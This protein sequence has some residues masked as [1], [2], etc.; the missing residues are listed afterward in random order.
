M[1][2]CEGILTTT[3]G[4]TSHAA[5]VARTMALPCI[6]GAAGLTIDPVR[7]ILTTASGQTLVADG[8]TVQLQGA[9]STAEP[10]TLTGTGV[11]GFGVLRNISGGNTVSGLATLAAAV[12]INSDADTL[13]LS[14][15]VSSANFPLTVGGAGNTT[16]SGALSLGSA[17]L[18]KDGSG[19]LTLSAGNTY[20][21]ATSVTNGTLVVAHSA[22]LGS[23]SSAVIGANASLQVQGGVT[24]SAIA[25]T[26]PN[27]RN[28]AGTNA[29]TGTITA[30]NG[31]ALTLQSDA[32]T[33]TV[34]AVAAQSADTTS[35]SLLLTGSA[36]GTISGL[37]TGASGL[38][39]T[40]SG[41]WTLSGANTYSVPTTVS[42][43]TLAAGAANA[44]SAN[45]AVTLANAAGATL[46][47]GGFNQSV[48]SL[49]GAGATGGSVTLGGTGVLTTGAN[50]SFD[51]TISGTGT[52][53]LTKTGNGVMTL[54]PTSAVTGTVAVSVSQ[55]TLLFNNTTATDAT[56]SV[57]VA[58]NAILGGKGVLGGATTI[59]SGGMLQ[60]GDGSAG[61]LTLG[62]LTFGANA[63]D[64]AKFRVFNLDATASTI[65]AGAI[66][67]NGGASTI[68]IYAV[69]GGALANG[70]YDLL[71]Y[72]SL[73]DPTAFAAP[74]SATIT[75]LSGRQGAT[76]NFLAGSGSAGTLQMIVSGDSPKWTGL[77]G[78]T[79]DG[80]WHLPTGTAQN[81]QL[82]AGATGTNYQAGDSVRFDDSAGSGNTTVTIGEGD[83]SPTSVTIDNATLA[84]VFNGAYGL[85]GSTGVVKNG[86]AA[87]TFNNPNNFAGGVTVNAGTLTF[88]GANTIAGGLTV[89]GGTLNL[90]AANT[91]T[92][93]I[94]IDDG[95]LVL[96][97]PGAIDVGNA[98]TFGAGASGDLRL[99]GNPATIVGLS[100]NATVGTPLIENG[101][102]SVSAILTVNLA[103]GTNTY[104]GVLQDG[105]AA[106]LG[107][108]KAGN[109]TLVLTGVNTF[110]G[111]AAV[112]GGV[113]QVGQGGVLSASDTAISA[114]AS[115]IFASNGSAAY[116]GGIT[117]AGSL[118]AQGGGTLT[119][120][121]NAAHTGG[122]TV[123]AGQT[124]A[125]SGSGRLSGAGAISLAG[126]LSSGTDN[127]ISAPIAGAGALS[128]TAGTLIL[129]GANS[130]AG[131][132][133]I[134][135]AATLQ[136]GAG[137]TTGTLGSAA[138]ITDNG[139][140]VI[141]RSADYAFATNV[142]GSGGLTA[143]MTSGAKLTLTGVNGYT[144]VTT[145][146]SGTLFISNTNVWS[147]SSSLVLGGTGTAGTLDLNGTSKTFTSL[148]T[149]GTASAQTITN[150]ATGT[151][152]ITFTGTNS[153]FGGSLAD[154]S[155]TKKIALAITGGGT[156]QL[157]STNAF[158]GGT[159]VAY[160]TAQLG[161]NNAFG[162]GSLTLGGVGTAGTLDLNGFS[163]SIGTFTLGSG[164]TASAQVVGNS[165]SS[166]DGVLTYTGGNL[167][168]ASVIQDTL[169]AGTR[170]TG[171][172]LAGGSTFILT[173]ANTFTGTLI[174]N[175]GNTLQ[176]GSAGTVGSFASPVANA[177]TL[178][179][180]RTDTLSLPATVA[181][182]GNGA[183]TLAQAG[184]VTVA[185]DDQFN[186]TGVLN[187]G[188]ANAATI[189][190]SLDLTNGSATFG[191]LLVRTN[192][193][194]ANTIAIGAGKTLT[195]TGAVT[196]GYSS[197]AS[198]TTVLTVT[199]AG[200]LAIGTSAS[201]TNNNIRIGGNVTDAYSNGGTLDLGGL[202]DFSAYLG[203]GYLRVGD[204]TNSSGNAT[205]SSTLVLAANSLVSAAFINASSP[206]SSVSEYLKLGSG[207]NV[208]NAATLA[209]GANTDGRSN[210]YLSFNGAS[211]TLKVRSQADTVNGRVTL[212]LANMPS[213]NSTGAN[214]IAG[215]DVTGHNADLMFGT[216]TIASRAGGAGY[217][218]GSLS[219]DTGTFNAND[220]VVGQLLSGS[221]TTGVIGGTV[222][223]GGGTVT[224]NSLTAAVKLGENTAANGTGSG[225]LNISGTAAVSV[226]GF[227]GVALRLGNASA[228]AGTANGAINLTGGT[229]TA[230]GSIVRGAS[231]GTSTATLSLDGG[232]LD[233]GGFNLGG[234]GSATGNLTAI[235]LASGTLKNVGDINYGSAFSKTAGA[236]SNTLIVDG[237]NSFTGAFTIASGTVQVGT[238][239]T[240]GTLGTSAIVDNAALVFNRGDAAAF[241]NAISGTGTVTQAGSGNLTLTGAN[242][243]AGLT[244]ISAG[245]LT[246]AAGA[247][248][249]TSG[250]TVNGAV[251]AAVDFKSGANLTL[252]ATATATVSGAGLT[253]GNVANAGTAADALNFTAS[254]GTITLVALSGAGKTT[255]GSA[256][257]ITGGISAGVVTVAGALTS[258]VSGGTTTVGGVATLTTV[259]N[260][261]LNLNGATAAIGTL[262]GG[263]VNLGTTA[264]TVNAGTFAGLIAGANGSLIKAS[265][266]TLTLSSTNT[267]GGGTAVNAGTLIVGN[268]GSLGS[269]AVT[270][271]SG[272]TLDLNSLGVANAITVATGGTILGGPD[273]SAVVTTGSTS[274]DTVL[275]GTGGLSKSDGG[276]L[277]LSTPN[278]YTGAT[279]ATGATA[280]I[281][282]AFLSD[283]SS[284]LGASSLTDPA[285][286]TLSA[287]AKLEFN[288]STNT[289]TARS[290]TVGGSAGIAATGTGTLEFTSASVLATTG[291]APALTLTAS[292]TG[293][294]R[295]A[296]TLDAGSNPLANLAI[297]G[298]GTWVIGTGANRFKGDVRIDAGAGSTIGFES[299]A[300]PSTAVIAVADGAK[301]RWES[302]NT[303]DLGGNL[304]IKAGDTAKLDL[305]ANTVV[306]NNAPTVATGTGSTVTLEKQ[307][308]GTLKIATNV[309]A[310]AFNV[311]L[312]AN[313]GLLT[314]NGS[315]GNVSL[316]SGSKLGGS[317]TVG[318]VTA[319]AGAIVSPGNSP[320]V[321]GGTTIRLDGGSIFEWQIQDAK[322]LTVNPGYDKL[323][324]SGNLDLTHASATNKITL[325][326]VSLLGAGNGTTLGD[327]LNFDKPGTVGLRPMVF[328]FASVA[329]T[330]LTNSG[331]QIS[332][333]F[334]ID[335]SQFTYSDGSAS[336]AGL[337]SIN[338]DS[339][340]HL[341]TVT[342]V[343]EPSTYGFGLGALALAAAA[344][345]R[346]RKTEP[347]KA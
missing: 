244:T 126:T 335:V 288:G 185:A 18:T 158:T 54:G 10:F 254:T 98:V 108:T 4:M 193:V 59:A 132:T 261:T 323:T 233:M 39:K 305:G 198:T 109:G 229:L 344:I 112:T 317:G 36:N 346:R 329:G 291:T 197:G 219:F 209:L 74:T 321:L 188:S 178:I 223:F 320:G 105:G 96:G 182:T 7:R 301:I 293:T 196:V 203:S 222:S 199:G 138:S 92:G 220:L 172:T 337:W 21:G 129:S 121:G 170:K 55:G 118:L 330:V 47:L 345:R 171:L 97:A 242:T 245:T 174:I 236:G 319:G 34:S 61:N 332:D 285:N 144:G 239:S 64:T 45:S 13:T 300:L 19:T 65:G 153:T 155:A 146:A 341:V 212:N 26:T 168:F 53:G 2:V 150:S 295:F 122:T 342:A 202:A 3:G 267:F 106:T 104:A 27:L 161:A 46:S 25:I 95:V 283:T 136:V 151:S 166:A 294:N 50:V 44:F 145:V 257:T 302:G 243:Y 327:P 102:A 91:L 141:S 331:E 37:I 237:T 76:L 68:T 189:A 213:G 60:A 278:F 268:I 338:W 340:N 241:A 191:S 228:A 205:K 292:N 314:V 179:F 271:A 347:T 14:G 56:V 90:N 247:L 51:G 316:A 70:T 20:S 116:A 157:A 28:L 5:V 100:T 173:G 274:V 225:T 195:I 181:V 148:A 31:G 163:Q 120:S 310:S 206:D 309:N 339:A 177:G 49:D 17:G 333:V 308:T 78:A 114:G 326:V 99:G 52:S 272:A 23:T 140:L 111:P 246:T 29:W 311:T 207:T 75:G 221:T 57:T 127:T 66:V 210:G 230:G 85:A 201:P 190:T 77:D 248:A 263:T 93:D 33:L 175:G 299:G 101:S 131:S 180:S 82:I 125:L 8:A 71:T 128:V 328:N 79:A 187:M 284:S 123:A 235:T 167:T 186:T 290:F 15:G 83:V 226:A 238:G 35:Q 282:A 160:G 81:W 208:F 113:L 40:G 227:S 142:G 22:A 275:T 255:F 303:T 298:T 30:Q 43:G 264:L 253:V 312:P 119:I 147:G 67:A 165:S 306:F 9:I 297:D 276:N 184:A 139:T 137:S 38:T 143:A 6:V 279:E 307:G 103:S 334:T 234:T 258:S 240:T 211:G 218:T 117:G 266:G 259:S 89:N 88:A 58:N 48:K 80:V 134:A 217:A 32:G 42:A 336:N 224:V 204:L 214:P 183:V 273:A 159:V 194:T 149:A 63:G 249:G 87:A 296:P 12:R 41:T 86:A 169:G 287:G 232:V 1:A 231:T 133:T 270:V 164:A 304:S 16:L 11:G 322:E 69:N 192:T 265:A 107:L 324:L 286:L 313:S 72:A 260:G 154:G 251:L 84:Y 250:V 262:N 280:V 315:I 124:L 216:V 24:V 200:S 162:T 152:T 343:P 256:A 73:N 289:S 130:Y 215:F 110:T 176:V 135:S 252:D 115:L 156:L 325:K 277:T 94:E 62:A 281:K 318:N 269:G